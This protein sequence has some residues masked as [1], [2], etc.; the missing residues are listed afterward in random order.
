MGVGKAANVRTN[1]ARMTAAFSSFKRAAKCIA[2][3]SRSLGGM[4]GAFLRSSARSA[5]LRWK[6]VVR[7]SSSAHC[8]RTQGFRTLVSGIGP[9]AQPL[10]ASTARARNEY[11]SPGPLSCVFNA[12]A[13]WHRGT[14][15][16]EYESRDSRIDWRRSAEGRYGRRHIANAAVR[17]Q[18]IRLGELGTNRHNPCDE[19]D[20]AKGDFWWC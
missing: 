18:M 20:C 17:C 5:T 12:E 1:S 9:S 13:Q 16:T 8:L 4:L 7:C 15:R 11:A 19:C 2:V 14:E 3:S 6:V 10:I